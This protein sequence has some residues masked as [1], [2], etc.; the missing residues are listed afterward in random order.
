MEKVDI[1]SS[2]CKVVL[3]V[4]FCNGLLIFDS[5]KFFMRLV[6]KDEKGFGL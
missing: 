4:L 1:F 2:F 3:K 6:F 5:E